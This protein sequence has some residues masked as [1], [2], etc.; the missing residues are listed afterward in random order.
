MT[1]IFI[2]IIIFIIIGVMAIMSS[3]T[4]SVKKE[5]KDNRS[6][7]QQINNCSPIEK[8]ID[9]KLYRQKIYGEM[10]YGKKLGFCNSYEIYE[11]S[12][13]LYLLIKGKSH[14]LKFNDILGADIIQKTKTSTKTELKE[15]DTGG[16]KTGS[17]VGRAVVGGLIAGPVGAIIGG[18]TANKGK[19]TEFVSTNYKENIFMLSIRLNSFSNPILQTKE[20]GEDSLDYLYS[21]KSVIDIIISKNKQSDR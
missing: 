2:L 9:E 14:V 13:T 3:N 17:M 1:A 12:E 5:K 10:S 4:Q 6:D 18:V 16:V 15:V 11:K 20:V 7:S 8:D 19:K 21:L